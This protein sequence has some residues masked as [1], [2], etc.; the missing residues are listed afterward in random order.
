M[1]LTRVRSIGHMASRRCTWSFVGGIDHTVQE[2][3]SAPVACS[4]VGTYCSLRLLPLRDRR[5]R[6][7]HNEGQ[8]KAAMQRS[9]EHSET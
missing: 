4:A 7:G 5:Q 6:H 9:S 8:S 3:S 2:I 1:S